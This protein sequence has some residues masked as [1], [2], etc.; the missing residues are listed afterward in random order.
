MGG[1]ARF[2]K[3]GAQRGR[4]PLGFGSG[5]RD[6]AGGGGGWEESLGNR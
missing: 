4:D 2:L 3:V 6:H 1:G 5:E